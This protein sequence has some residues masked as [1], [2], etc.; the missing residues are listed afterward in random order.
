MSCC[1]HRISVRFMA[2][3]HNTTANKKTAQA[4]N[5]APRFLQS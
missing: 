4:P 3:V 5:A 2:T 1:N